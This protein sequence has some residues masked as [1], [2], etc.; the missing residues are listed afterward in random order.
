MQVASSVKSQI[1]SL[2]TG[3]C[4]SAVLD[5]AKEGMSCTIV[6]NEDH[7]NCSPNG[8]FPIYDGID[9]L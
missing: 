2:Q 4:R 6:L 3:S 7:L 1:Y 9:M 8:A 5:T